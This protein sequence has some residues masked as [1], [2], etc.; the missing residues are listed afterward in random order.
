[1]ELGKSINF[2]NNKL[3]GRIYEKYQTISDFAS[4]IGI[5]KSA[6]SL[7]LGNKRKLS[8]ED[9]VLFCEKLDIPFEE[10]GY[11]FFDVDFF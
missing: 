5:D 10:I 9:I 6:I 2:N 1:M 7:T 8:R 11:Y 4:A 3:R